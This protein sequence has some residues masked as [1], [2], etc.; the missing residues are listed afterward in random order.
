M[1]ILMFERV[2]FSQT[3]EFSK[4]VNTTTKKMCLAATAALMETWIEQ[5]N[6]FFGFWSRQYLVLLPGQLFTFKDK[7]PTSDHWRPTTA[8]LFID[9]QPLVTMTGSVATVSSGGELTK[10]RFESSEEAQRFREL[11]VG[12]P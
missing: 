6:G 2:S 11:I 9:E 7:N 5:P 12:V 1:H 8:L 10:L 3:F 4:K